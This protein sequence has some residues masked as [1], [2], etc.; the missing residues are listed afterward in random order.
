MF[1]D[2]VCEAN[3]SLGTLK[4]VIDLVQGTKAEPPACLQV[5]GLN[6]KTF[7]LDVC[8]QKVIQHNNAM[9]IIEYQF[10]ILSTEDYESNGRK[11]KNARVVLKNY[12][13]GLL[14]V[15]LISEGLIFIDFSIHIF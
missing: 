12:T 6:S 1:G 8:T 7:D 9:D 2:Y 5:R 4:R 10:E 13:E 11:F 3:N 14:T 15:M